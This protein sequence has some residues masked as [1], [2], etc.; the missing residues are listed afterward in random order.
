MGT[1]PGR[2]YIHIKAAE[3]SDAVDMLRKMSESMVLLELTLPPI[4]TSGQYRI[5]V[6]ASQSLTQ[7]SYPSIRYAYPIARKRPSA[8]QKQDQIP[9]PLPTLESTLETLSDPPY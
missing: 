2:S 9:M 1:L 4:V 8:M 5:N 3:R 7:T 6:V